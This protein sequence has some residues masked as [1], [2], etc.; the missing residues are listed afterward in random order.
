MRTGMTLKHCYLLNIWRFM[1]IYLR[2][3][4]PKEQPCYGN[5][6]ETLLSAEHLEIYA[7]IFEKDLPKGAAMLRE[8]AQQWRWS[9]QGD[10]NGVIDYV[11]IM[12]TVAQLAATQGD[13]QLQRVKLHVGKECGGDYHLSEQICEGSSSNGGGKEVGA[14]DLTWSY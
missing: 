3:I 13:N 11:E 9:L 7:D 5:D 10:W 2:R 12:G 1:R 8:Y 6:A 4:Y 14:H